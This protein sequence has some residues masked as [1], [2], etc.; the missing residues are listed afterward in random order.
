MSAR[1]C[2]DAAV[3]STGSLPL[4]PFLID[5]FSLKG[6]HVTKSLLAYWLT[7][8]FLSH[9]SPAFSWGDAG[10][11]IVARVADHYLDPAVRNKIKIILIADAT[12][13]TLSR[14]IAAEATWADRF[15]DSDRDTTKVHYEQTRQWHFIDLEVHGGSLKAA[16]FGHPALPVGVP[17]SRGPAQSCIVDKIEQ[18]TTELKSP[19]TAAAEKLRALQ[20]LLHFVGDV[21]QPLH[22]SDDHDRG[23]N[24]KLVAATG[25]EAGNLHHYWD[26]EFVLQLGN[27][28][29]QVAQHLI[30][31]I[32]AAQIKEWSTGAASD[33]AMESLDIAKTTAYGLLPPP[34][35]R[36][37]Y[38]LNKNYVHSA[39]AASATQLSRAGVRLAHVLNEALK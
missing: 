18:F 14:D 38:F 24:E 11:E 26:A 29:A 33:W 39:T 31:N 32:T 4:P 5:W 12:H 35:S 6:K 1:K 17:A 25:I 28:P 16:C 2:I 13:L 34:N 20:F 7:L 21:H 8:V 19:A 22:A 37:R 15:R 30:A 27:Q 10:H 9:A 36:G 23:G 3:H